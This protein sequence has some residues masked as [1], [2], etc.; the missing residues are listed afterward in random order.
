MFKQSQ[1]VFIENQDILW[2]RT[3]WREDKARI[4]VMFPT[5]ADGAWPDGLKSEP[6]SLAA[7][8]SVRNLIVL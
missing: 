4:A 6:M 7:A 2:H 8:L 3:I 5:T 1:R